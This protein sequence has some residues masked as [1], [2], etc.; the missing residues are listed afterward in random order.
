MM[1]ERNDVKLSS[2]LPQ[3]QYIL[4]K[5]SLLGKLTT[6][7]RMIIEVLSFNEIRKKRDITGET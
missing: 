7:T 4:T 2:L 6:M 5:R 3:R 1:Q